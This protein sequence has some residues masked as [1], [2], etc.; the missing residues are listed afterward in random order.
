MPPNP[1]SKIR[2]IVELIGDRDQFKASIKEM[3]DWCGWGIAAES[4]WAQVVWELIRELEKTMPSKGA[5]W[6]PAVQAYLRMCTDLSVPVSDRW[7]KAKELLQANVDMLSGW[8]RSPYREFAAKSKVYRQNGAYFQKDGD[9]V[10]ELYGAKTALEERADHIASS[11]GNSYGSLRDLIRIFAL[12]NLEEAFAK[13]PG[14]FSAGVTV[15]LSENDHWTTFLHWEWQL[16]WPYQLRPT[17]WRPNDNHCDPDW[18]CNDMAAFVSE[19]EKLFHDDGHISKSPALHERWKEKFGKST[20][21]TGFALDTIL[22]LGNEE[23]EWIDFR[24][25]TYRWKNPTAA[26]YPTVIAT[27]GPGETSEDVAQRTFRFI[28]H[29]S[30]RT[31]HGIEIEFGAQTMSS[32]NPIA[33]KPKRS[34]S[35]SYP[36]SYFT[37]VSGK[38]LDKLDLA[39]SLYRE[40]ASSPS[41]YYAFLSFYKVVY[42]PGEK[43]Q[44]VKDWINAEAPKMRN[45]TELDQAELKGTYAG[46]AEKYIRKSGRN[47]TAHVNLD[48][49][50]KVLDPDK[51]EDQRKIRKDLNFI[52]ELARHAIDSGQF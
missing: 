13:N 9:V 36:G 38:S 8:Q 39:L 42:L 24:G 14:D 18:L 52:R 6:I 27:H 35:S 49:A 30:F 2:E 5:A 33:V 31:D 4:T 7:A 1:A 25:H 41:P 11:L 50:E 45:F 20:Q 47:A 12:C 28:S 43:S 22:T 44:K 46:D 51:L 16:N 21:Q 40:G 15:Y 17:R 48:G 26:M 29:L 19:K 34:G 3:T 23:E 37:E 32:M 10:Y